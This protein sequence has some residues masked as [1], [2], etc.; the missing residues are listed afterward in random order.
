MTNN[1]ATASTSGSKAPFA[2]V[3]A[4]NNFEDGI[5]ISGGIVSGCLSNQNGGYGLR[6]NSGINFVG[7]SN[8]MFPA[9]SLGA[10]FGTDAVNTGGNLCAA[11][12]TC[13]Q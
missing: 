4:H 1:A 3:I 6:T 5:Q 10:I 8:N 9:N 11:D 13:G 7:Y 2:T 12:P